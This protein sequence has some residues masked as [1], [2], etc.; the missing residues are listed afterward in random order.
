V[1]ICASDNFF[2][3][4]RTDAIGS[5]YK[6]SQT[7]SIKEARSQKKNAFITSTL[8]HNW[9]PICIG[10]LFNAL[11]ICVMHYV[12]MTAMEFDGHI[13]WNI[14]LVCVTAFIAY[15]GS[16]S[17]FWILM[18]VMV[19]YPSMEV[20]R[21]LSA[22]ICGLGILG[23]HEV[24]MSAATF[25]YN[26]PDAGLE[27]QV[28]SDYAERMTR[29][30]LYINQD[31][32]MVCGIVCASI[33]SFAGLVLAL[34]D[35]RAWYYSFARIIRELDINCGA[36]SS[37]VLENM[38]AGQVDPGSRFVFDSTTDEAATTT[39]HATKSIP[40]PYAVKSARSAA[41]FLELYRMLRTK[42]VPG[43]DLSSSKVLIQS[44]LNNI[45]KSR[46]VESSRCPPSPVPP[47]TPPTSMKPPPLASESLFPAAAAVTGSQRDRQQQTMPLGERPLFYSPT[48]SPLEAAYVVEVPSTDS[49]D[50][51][52]LHLQQT[53][54]SW[55]S[56]KANLDKNAAPSGQANRDAVKNQRTESVRATDADHEL[57]MQLSPRLW[58]RR[59][60]SSARGSHDMLVVPSEGSCHRVN[61]KWSFPTETGITEEDPNLIQSELSV[62]S[63]V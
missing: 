27:T 26:D 55:M 21:L 52:L 43:R 2:S 60:S 11:G 22:V 6:R 62:I 3:K 31:T 20:L 40:E 44:R 35:L 32:A 46:L 1:L 15:V 34:N 33:L 18:R 59:G 54:R 37:P 53:S 36:N 57:E 51:I 61:D 5:F 9:Q 29:D 47:S 14:P 63:I 41:N 58:Q 56:V 39:E 7:L 10:A 30:R 19:L 12:G 8:F 25:E 42:S 16:V 45:S 4:D 38:E 13:N 50:D 48:R 17:I 28:I 49:K 24:G 23:V